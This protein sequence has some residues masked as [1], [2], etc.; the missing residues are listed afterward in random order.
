MATKPKPKV[1][2]DKTVSAKN[3]ALAIR[4]T[5]KKATTAGGK[6]GSGNNKNKRYTF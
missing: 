5:R 3:L 1:K 2:I 4:K 6:T